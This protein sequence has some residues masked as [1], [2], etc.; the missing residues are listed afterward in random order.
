MFRFVALK[1]VPPAKSEVKDPTCKTAP[2]PG[3]EDAALPALPGRGLPK[4][5]N[6]A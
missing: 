2:H 3:V 4:P 6:S 1:G 5:R